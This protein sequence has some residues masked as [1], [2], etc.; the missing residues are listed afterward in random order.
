[1]SERSQIVTRD[2]RLYHLGVAPDEVGRSVFL[3][4]DPARAYKVAARFDTIEHEVKNREFVTLSGKVRGLSMTV[5]GTGIGTD[6]VEIA[7]I[8]L[9][10]AHALDLET[11]LP[12]AGGEALDI[13]RIGTS[14]GVQPDVAAGTLCVAEYALG[15]DSTGVFYESPPADVNVVE[16]EQEARRLLD[17]AVGSGSRF[18]GRLGVYASKANPEVHELLKRCAGDGRMPSESGITVSAPGFY[19]PSSRRIAGLVNTVPDIKGALARLSVKGLRVL[20]MEM[21]SSL[22]FHLAGALGHRAGTIC[23]A[24]SQPGSHASVVDYDACIEAA[25]T[26]AL[27]AALELRDTA[28]QA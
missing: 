2:G 26:V 7:M 23:P 14:G 17:E 3:V 10:A 28:A 15:L 11:A 1:M 21:E 20:N 4:G 19:G 9:H 6:N 8:E 16:I 12:R 22:L 5:I 27:E 13:I 18:R 25:I 24:I